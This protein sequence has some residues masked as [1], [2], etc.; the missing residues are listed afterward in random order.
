MELSFWAATDVGKKREINED[1]FLV[2]KKLNLFIVADG[3]G[4]HASGEVAS[5]LAVHEFLKAVQAGHDMVER[6]GK[7]DASVRP[8]EVLTLL[9]NAVQAAGH[10]V[11]QKGQQE[12]EKR[13]MGTTTSALLI[14]GDRGFI[15]HVGDSRVY[16]LRAGQV[17][18]LTED[19]S[20]VNELIRRGRVTKEGFET[21]PYKAYKNAVTRAVGVYETVQGDTID[22]ELLPGD[23][24]LLCSDGLHAYLTDARIIEMFKGDDV[25]QLPKRLVDL[26]NAGGGHD[27]ITA[28]VVRV[29]RPAVAAGEAPEDRAEELARKVEVLRRMPL[30]RHLVYKEILR[31]LNV[32]RVKEF[33]PGEEIIREGTQGDEMY[34]LLR[35]KIR[36]HKNDAFITHLE[37]GS[38]IGEMALIDRRHPRSAS[39]TAEER[40]R[41]LIVTRKDFYEIIRTEPQLST[42]LLWAFTQVLADR[43]RK[44]TAE[45][46]GAR[47][48]AGAEDLT[49]DVL[50]EES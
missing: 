27:N 14:A 42:K 10:A 11:Y 38:H 49:A 7:G 34:V 2:D 21:S 45:L 40:S 29:E 6:Y 15:A 9:E 8:Q 35:G 41:V 47:L 19:H 33:A 4:G 13:G 20:L 48:E 44:T 17:V 3:M 31:L 22:F 12:P 23:Q 39:A 50:F 46:S 32:T 18:Q 1:S 30:F 37:P 36:L 5:K 25:K 16:M 24:F 28:I 26:A 43:L